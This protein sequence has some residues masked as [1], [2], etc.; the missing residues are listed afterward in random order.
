MRPV[1]YQ[2]FTRLFANRQVPLRANG[3]I[4]E[5][6][7]AKMND[8][9]ETTLLKIKR[10]G[11]THVWYTGIIR[12][13]TTTDYTDYGLPRQTPMVVKGRAGSPYTITDYYDVD[14]DLAVD[15][16]RRME[17]FE[18]LVE[19][20][21]KAGLKVVIDFV[22]NHVAREYHSICKPAD[23]RDLGEDD[24]TNMHFSTSNNFYYCWGMPLDTSALPQ[25]GE[26]YVEMPAR[27][28]G[29]DH[30]DNRPSANDW[31]ETVKLNYG[32]DYC[33][34]G[35]RSEHFNPIPDTWWKMTHIL[36]FWAGKNVDAFRCDMAE[37][38]PAA[39]WHWATDKVKYARK[40]NVKFIGEVYDPAQYRNYINA[41]FDYLYDKVGMYDCLRDVVCHRRPA[42]DI[43]RQWQVN[44]DILSHMLYFLENHDEQRIASDFFAADPRKGLPAMVVC[45]WLN[46]SPVMIYA[47]QEMGER[48]MDQEGFSGSDGRTTIFDYWAPDTLRR[49]GDRRRMKREEKELFDVYTKIL[50]LANQEDAFSKGEFFDLMYVNPAMERQFAFIRKYGRQMVLVVA[51]FDEKDAECDVVVPGHAFDYWQM[52]EGMLKAEDLLS[53]EKSLLMFAKDKPLD[54]NVPAL[55]ARAWKMIIED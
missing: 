35:G 22:P 51:N 52:K 1:I 4:E 3:T 40:D 26:P 46:T 2:I 23:V 18:A 50:T 41:G 9:D 44:N 48:G 34:A 11:V 27:A 8:I 43:T 12:H 33:D 54:I 49:W 5:N 28:T 10:M 38:V 24:D 29:N 31:Y 45:A 30:F 14:P 21:H 55:S 53:G 47:G 20:T 36:L 42:A 17:E 6:G 37:M 32:I 7:C 39:F 13:A 25:E 16:D 19:R 15:V